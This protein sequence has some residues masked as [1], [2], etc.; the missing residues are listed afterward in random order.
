MFG[1]KAA[2]VLD[3]DPIYHVQTKAGPMAGGTEIVGHGDLRE[4]HHM[5]LSENRLNP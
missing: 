1:R 2:P 5:G 4:Y 3:G